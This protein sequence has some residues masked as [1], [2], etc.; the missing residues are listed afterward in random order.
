MNVGPGYCGINIRHKQL[1]GFNVL[2]FATVQLDF[3]LNDYILVHVDLS[4]K[5]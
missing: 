4:T 1:T 3:E 2:T 5:I